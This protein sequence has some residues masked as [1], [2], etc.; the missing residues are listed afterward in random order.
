MYLQAFPRLMIVLP[1]DKRLNESQASRLLASVFSSMQ[2]FSVEHVAQCSNQIWLP[3]LNALKSN[4][5]DYFVFKVAYGHVVVV[6]VV[7]IFIFSR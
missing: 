2:V 3:A 1:N 6:V 5:C 7:F 4:S